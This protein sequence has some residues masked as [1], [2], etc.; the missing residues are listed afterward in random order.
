MDEN[1]FDHCWPLF[2]SELPALEQYHLMAVE[3]G[4]NSKCLEILTHLYS[5]LLENNADRKSLLINLGGGMISDLGGFLAATY[6]RGIPYINVPTSLLAM[7]DA[8]IGA[9]TGIDFQEHKNIIGSFYPSQ[10]IVVYPDFLATLPQQEYLSAMAEIIKYALMF[11][12]K[13]WDEICSD[14]LINHPNEIIL[15]WIKKC[16]EIKNK[17]IAI[18]PL[19]KNERKKLNFGHTIGHALESFF[20]KQDATLLHGQA[21]AWGMI[22]ETYF[23]VQQGDFP[24]KDFQLLIKKALEICPK[25]IFHSGDIP[26]ISNYLMHDKKAFNNQIFLAIPSVPG[27]G[28]INK[29]ITQEEVEYLLKFLIDL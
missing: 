24:E 19:E 14:S 20:M 8:S 3:P 17:V 25:P 2:I 23:A 13:L 7:V 21:I 16:A 10:L 1:T 6:M 22:A 9:K 26:E 12:S 4:E 5:E 27:H 18:D 11:D 28:I 15:E 29:K